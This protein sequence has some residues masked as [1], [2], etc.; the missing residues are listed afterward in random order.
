MR[1]A[2]RSDQ[3]ETDTGVQSQNVINKKSLE[4]RNL[5]IVSNFDI[6]ISNSDSYLSIW[7]F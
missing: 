6:W 2:S 5:E 1:E 7:A 3:S 4:F